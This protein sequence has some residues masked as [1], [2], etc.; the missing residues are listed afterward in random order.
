MVRESNEPRVLIFSQRNLIRKNPFRCAHFEFED[1]I[2]QIDAVELLAPPIDPFSS[3]QKFAK[4]I[5]YH[6]PIAL[7]PGIK[8]GP[9]KRHYDLFL[10]VCGDPTDLLRINAI[11]GW[12]ENCKTAV[13]LIDEVWVR[14]MSAY[15]N[16]L[17]MLKKFDFVILYYS[18][19]VKHLNERIGSKCVF[20]PPGVDAIRFCP[21]PDPPHR[22][23]DIYS[24]GRRSEKT[25]RK[26]LK[27]AAENGI[28][29]L[30]DSVAA[31]Q[32]L[33][34][35]EH[36]ALFANVAKRSRYFIVNPGLIDRPDIRGGQIEIGSRY[37]EATA[38][39]TIMVGERPNNGEFEKLFDWPDALIDLPYDSSE[40]DQAIHQFEKEPEREEKSRRTSVSQSLLRHDWA[41]RWETILK[42]AGL[43]PA[44]ELLQRKDHL[45]NLAQAA[46]QDKLPA[47][48]GTS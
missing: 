6:T 8:T 25:H 41:Y 16:F 29:Y 13:C 40:I 24:I 22:V 7:N 21:Y 26:L 28:F 18:Q 48:L 36:R 47:T 23:V 34:A 31:D 43:E 19:S 33:S 1:T 15:R 14:Q 10:S 46:L 3:R 2:S 12:R 35:A 44:P 45:R 37:F 11:P 9:L 20:M 5:A 17:D 27:M 30:H 4:Q 39:G 38:S 42:L 32:V